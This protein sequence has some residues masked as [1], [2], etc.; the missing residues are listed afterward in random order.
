M[1]RSKNATSLLPF[2]I[3]HYQLCV[4]LANPGGYYMLYRVVYELRLA[5]LHSDLLLLVA[6]I[7][8]F[9]NRNSCI[10]EYEFRK[11]IY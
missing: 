11:A 9:R 5:Y 8:L 6:S 3:K 1:K 2:P 7:V 10:K 4:C